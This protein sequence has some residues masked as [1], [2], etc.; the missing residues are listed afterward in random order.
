MNY[1]DKLFDNLCDKNL[2]GIKVSFEDEGLDFIDV[3]NIKKLCLNKGIDLLLKIGGAEAK[4]DFKDANKI[5][6]QKIVA[7][8]IESSFALSKYIKT[9]ESFV[10]LKKVSLGFNMES[11][12]AYD[13]IHE[14][15]NTNEF[16]RLSAITVGRG[17]LTESFGYDR[18][19]GAVNSNEIYKVTRDTFLIGRN[20]GLKCYLGGSMN[21][22]SEQFVN[23]LLKENLLD[24]FETRNVVFSIKALEIYS[25]QELINIAFKFEQSKMSVRR[26]YYEKLYNEDLTRLERL[27]GL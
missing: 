8:M 2:L 25:F 6:V 21:V 10:D 26:S 17:D 22:E 1:N 9:A 5:G 23:Q 19:A 11:R 16:Q 14:M 20:F 15:S 4:R 3:L 13:N 7:P 12:Q 18:Y 27:K 24:Y